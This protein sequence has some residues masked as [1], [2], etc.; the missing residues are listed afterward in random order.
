LQH[1]TELSAPLLQ[2]TLVDP[3]VG[4]GAASWVEAMQRRM[5]AILAADWYEKK[6]A[7]CREAYAAFCTIR[8]CGSHI[9]IGNGL[10][11]T[12]YEIWMEQ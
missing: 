7:L 9:N 5:Q 11:E 2:S 3:L 4:W 1:W 8:S 6:A 12:N 10:V